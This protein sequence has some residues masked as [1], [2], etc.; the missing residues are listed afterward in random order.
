MK[1]RILTLFLLASSLLFTAKDSSAQQDPQYSH[2]MFN[3]FVFNPSLAGSKPS[4]SMIGLFRAQYVGFDGGPQTQ[5]IS[6]HMPAPGLKGGVG[7]HIINDQIGFERNLHFAA[8]YAYK[9]ELPT[10]NLSAGISVGFLQRTL[11]GSKLKALTPGDPLIPAGTVNAVKPDVNFGLTYNTDAYYVGFSTTHLTTPNMSFDVPGTS[12]YKSVVHYYLTGGYNLV[13]SPSIEIKPSVMIKVAKTSS[14]DINA[15]A[16]YNQKYWGGLSYRLNDAIVAIAGMNLTERIKM[17]YS[18]D[19]TLSNLSL[20][21]NGSTG[22]HEILLG[23]DVVFVK[24]IKTDVI[25]K[26]PRFL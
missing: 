26:T 18:Y 25:I 1:N 22:S 13:L 12:E 16:F 5:T 10:G 15:L 3:S 20:T 4:L 17:S 24:K 11:D 23:Y 14:F 2:Y 6:A 9:Y 19:Y 21:S 7:V 8:S